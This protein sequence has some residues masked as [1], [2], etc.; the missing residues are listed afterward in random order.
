[1]PGIAVGSA[2]VI[3]GTRRASLQAQRLS[4][5]ASTSPVSVSGLR[6][7]QEADAITGKVTTDPITSWTD[8]SGSGNHLIEAT[9]P[10]T[11]RATD[12]PNSLPCVRFDGTDD[13]LTTTGL[14]TD[15]SLTA[16]LVV[17]KRSAPSASS[18]T[19]WS[20]N[21]TS[22]FYAD[23]RED[24]AK[25]NYY[26]AGGAVA[27]LEGT[28]TSW[29]IVVIRENS[30]ASMDFYFNGGTAVNINPDDDGIPAT[31]ARSIGALYPTGNFGDYDYYAYIE[32]DSA[33]S[34]ANTNL[35]GN[36]LSAKTAITWTAV[37]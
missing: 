13:I 9:N 6:F 24:A 18:M 26:G 3:L 34:A 32:Y 8:A 14:A 23:S 4:S 2:L 28:S 10:P 21:T 35:I 37:S 5:S 27:H 17:K 15:S 11:Y 33:L 25:Y 30:A 20:G 29:T 12:G 7:W 31:T 19:A 22:Q 16:F 1:M 36:Y